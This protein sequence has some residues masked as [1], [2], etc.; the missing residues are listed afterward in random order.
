[1]LPEKWF[2]E[3]TPE[4]KFY[5]G[6]W[7]TR[8][9]LSRE[10]NSGYC[11]SQVD[12]SSHVGYYYPRRNNIPADYQEIT[13]EQ[14]LEHVLKITRGPGSHTSKKMNEMMEY[15][16]F[17]DTLNPVIRNKFVVNIMRQGGNT[18]SPCFPYEWV[19]RIR[20]RDTDEGQTYWSK[21]FSRYHNLFIRNQTQQ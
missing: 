17:L 16:E 19:T 14:F 4:N 9:Q 21:V 7:R 20:W 11:L 5:I 3:V 13:T 18:S 6:L 12:H 1:M 2:I 15:H 10:T 8:G